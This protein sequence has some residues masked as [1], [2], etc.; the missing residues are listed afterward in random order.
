MSD[1]EPIPTTD[2]ILFDDHQV[3]SFIVWTDDGA[4]DDPG[5][6][7]RMRSVLLT[8]AEESKARNVE[9]VGPAYHPRGLPNYGVDF[10]CWSM[11]WKGLVRRETVI[12][13]ALMAKEEGS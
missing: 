10:A 11:A 1:D 3:G 8:Q 7:E 6:L 13:V 12:R 2:H 9:L 5:F 4:A